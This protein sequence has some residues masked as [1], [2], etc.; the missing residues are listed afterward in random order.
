MNKPEIIKYV[1]DETGSDIFKVKQII[2]VFCDTIISEVK[3]GNKVRL[4][5]FGVFELRHRAAKKGRNPQTGEDIIIPERTVPLFRP[6][7]EFKK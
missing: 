5:G 2:N 4:S 3:Q 6:G 7:K 1:S